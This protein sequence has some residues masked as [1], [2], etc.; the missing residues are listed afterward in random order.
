M[1]GV[2]EGMPD[3]PP[4]TTAEGRRALAL[5]RL[6]FRVRANALMLSRVVPFSRKRRPA[7]FVQLL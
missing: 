5:V 1:A 7:C 6:D 2:Y 3:S 4:P